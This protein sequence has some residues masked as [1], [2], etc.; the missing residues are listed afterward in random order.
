MALKAF[1]ELKIEINPALSKEEQMA[2]TANGATGMNPRVLPE[3][4]S[5]LP[6]SLIDMTIQLGHSKKLVH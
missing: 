6:V 2:L 5:F 4:L 1:K 3:D